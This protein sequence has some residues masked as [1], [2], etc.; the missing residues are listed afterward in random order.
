ML[1]AAAACGGERAPGQSTISR[2]RFVKVNVALR[3]IDPA[4]ADAPQQRAGVLEAHSV[5]EDELQNFVSARQRNTAEL[6]SIWDEIRREL[7]Q[8]AEPQ[9]VVEQDTIL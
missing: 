5:T 9:P 8:Q 4:A 1:L 3:Q 2:E 6:A 7:E